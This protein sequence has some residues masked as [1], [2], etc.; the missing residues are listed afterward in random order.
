MICDILGQLSPSKSIGGFNVYGLAG[1]LTA[2]DGGDIWSL[3]WL[4][5]LRFCSG[6]EATSVTIFSP[7][8]LVS[9]PLTLFSSVLE[10]GA[11]VFDVSPIVAASLSSS[12]PRA[13]FRSNDDLIEWFRLSRSRLLLGMRTEE[14]P[15]SRYDGTADFGLG[16]SVCESPG[17]IASMLCCCQEMIING[18]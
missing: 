1:R 16:C 17:A 5:T 14:V 6:C 2:V 10:A 18:S 4:L 9:S 11:F 8:A 13:C 7:L 3:E 15:F 12:G